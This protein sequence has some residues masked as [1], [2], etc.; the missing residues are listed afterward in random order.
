MEMNALLPF[1][2]GHTGETVGKISNRLLRANTEHLKI[3]E[4]SIPHTSGAYN[5]LVIRAR[6]RGKSGEL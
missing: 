4:R 1:S 5:L 3:M 6:K 2:L